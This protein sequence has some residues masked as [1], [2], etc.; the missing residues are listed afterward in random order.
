MTMDTE[1]TR[2]VDINF[3]PMSTLDEVFSTLRDL[4]ATLHGIYP[5]RNE[6]GEYGFLVLATTEAEEGFVRRYLE[7]KVE[8]DAEA[9]AREYGCA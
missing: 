2:R 7:D 9:V 6:R 5:Q 4:G 8:R 1:R 3:T